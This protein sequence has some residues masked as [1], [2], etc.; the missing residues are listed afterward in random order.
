MRDEEDRGAG[1]GGV[2]D[3][4]E[5]PLDPLARQEHSRLVQ[6]EHTVA[7]ADAA[8]LLDRAH[9]REQRPLDRLEL[10]DERARIEAQAVPLER[11]AGAGPLAAP[12]DAEPV[13][14]RRDVRDAEVL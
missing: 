11:V 10:A 2:A 8:V 9:D 1:G 7:A 4:R 3:E 12:R 13:A 14:R 5:Q 6:H